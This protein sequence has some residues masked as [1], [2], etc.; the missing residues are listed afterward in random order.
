LVESDLSVNLKNAKNSK[1]AL[2]AKS[3]TIWEIA[4]LDSMNAHS[5][6]SR[7]NRIINIP[8]RR[9]KEHQWKSTWRIVLSSKR[10]VLNVASRFSK[11]RSP[12]T[13]A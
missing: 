2:R 10:S 11:V 5:N 8:K 7:F 9:F 4:N 1:M 3:Y 13:T 12:S 6:A